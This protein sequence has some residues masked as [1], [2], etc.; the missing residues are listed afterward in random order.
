MNVIEQMSESS[1]PGDEKEKEEQE[2]EVMIWI[3]TNI[4][5]E[6]EESFKTWHKLNR[7]SPDDKDRMTVLIEGNDSVPNTFYMYSWT[8]RGKSGV[9]YPTQLFHL[10]GSDEWIV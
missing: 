4:S 1:K 5:K 8:G 2:E 10:P 6:T 3:S 7:E 9:L